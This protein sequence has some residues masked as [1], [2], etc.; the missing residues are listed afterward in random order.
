MRREHMHIKHRHKLSLAQANKHSVHTAKIFTHNL[1]YIT[2]QMQMRTKVRSSK[3]TDTR[4]EKRAVGSDDPQ[5]RCDE[6]NEKGTVYVSSS[7]EWLAKDMNTHTHTH[8]V[9]PSPLLGGFSGQSFHCLLAR[10]TLHLDNVEGIGWGHC[11]KFSH[12]A[13][14]RRQSAWDIFSLRRRKKK[15]KEAGHEA[16][17]HSDITLMNR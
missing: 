9:D 6:H 2:K 10:A 15:H 5:T 8:R 13:D 17:M 4:W 1:S 11:P 3:Y 7:S 12:V 16:Y 14:S